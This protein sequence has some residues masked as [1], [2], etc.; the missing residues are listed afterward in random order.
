MTVAH[1]PTY[2]AIDLGAS[3]GR[4]VVGTLDEDGMHVEEVHRSD[5]V[6]RR[7][8]RSGGI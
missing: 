8:A 4:A 2:L 1:R 3:S 6:E 5:P 7:A